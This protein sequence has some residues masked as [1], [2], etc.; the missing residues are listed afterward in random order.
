MPALPTDERRPN[1]SLPSP[2]EPR[3]V[4]ATD[5]YLKRWTFVL[6]VAGVWIVAAA[7]GLGLYYWWFHSIDKTP[8]GLRRAGLPG[9][10]HRRAA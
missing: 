1:R 8:A 4:P 10:V 9:R 6:V 5:Q 7:I 2:H 3:R